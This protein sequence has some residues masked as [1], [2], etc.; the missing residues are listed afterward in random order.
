[1]PEPS[2]L[3]AAELLPAAGFTIL[4]ALVVAV[5]LALVGGGGSTPAPLPPPILVVTPAPAA[6]G[7]ASPVSVAAPDPVGVSPG[8]R[9]QQID[10][11][12]F[13]QGGVFHIPARWVAGFYRVYDVASRTFGVNWLLLAS[14][15]AQE[16]SFSTAA[17]TYR[18]L[19]FAGCC[20]G[21][22]QFNVTNR[23]VS[24]W[25]LVAD[26]YRYG[27]RPAGYPKPTPTH[28]SIYDDF[29]ALMAGARLLAASGARIA[30]DA[31]AWQAAYDY[32]GHDATGVLYADQVLGRAISWSEHGFCV[33][34]P[35][36]G[37]MVAAVHAAYGAPVQAALSSAVTRSGG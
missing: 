28:P 25:S 13:R 22:M 33:N 7:V 20:G 19:N 24:T 6:A 1:M 14:V 21:P 3:Q 31:S 17:S 18:G 10:L 15:H 2:R 34:C 4:L 9:Q 8:A 26:S 27:V 30:L 29:D 36:D 5:T 23:P 32:Y 16:T 11:R 35:L 37:G 12:R